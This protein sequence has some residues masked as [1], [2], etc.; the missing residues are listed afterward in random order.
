MAGP[1]GVL[2]ASPVAVTTEVENVDGEPP[3]GAGSKSDSGHH[4]S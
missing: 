1:L 4:R 2:A 3:G